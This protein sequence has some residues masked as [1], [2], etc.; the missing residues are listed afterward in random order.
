MTLEEQD[1]LRR[2]DALAA[3]AHDGQFRADGLTPLVEHPR[4]VRRVLEEFGVTDA[5]LLAAA[6]VHDVLED[7]EVTR[8]DLAQALG[9]EVT[10]VVE[11]VTVI[12]RAGE[13]RRARVQ[14]HLSDM[15]TA[16]LRGQVLRLA[17]ALHNTRD[18][19]G[20]K[21]SFRA[22][23]LSEKRLFAVAL[24]KAH[25]ALAARLLHTV[26][27]ALSAVEAQAV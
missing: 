5:V 21:P 25:P 26:D 12:R 16:S 13:S 22:L 11:E 9:L 19:D 17:D 23:W 8:G 18:S 1:L 24:S 3:R 4:G 15:R 27:Q 7:T 2:A 10:A 20:L 14:R 6:L